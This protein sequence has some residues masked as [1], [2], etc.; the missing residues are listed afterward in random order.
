MTFPD[1]SERR[2]RALGFRWIFGFA[3]GA[4]GFIQ[5]IFK[6]VVREPENPFARISVPQTLIP[7]VANRYGVAV[8]DVVDISAITPPIALHRAT[9]TAMDKERLTVRAGENVF[10]VRWE[11][12]IHLR[13]ANGG[14]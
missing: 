9:L 5:L 3:S 12:L 10:T 1:P 13:K 8:D 14:R 6:T 7:E 11:N 4:I 2:F